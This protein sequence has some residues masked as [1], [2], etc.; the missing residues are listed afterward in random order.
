MIKISFYVVIFILVIL[1]IANLIKYHKKV[2]LVLECLS[3]FIMILDLLF[4]I[5]TFKQQENIENVFN[6]KVKIFK[7]E[8]KDIDVGNV[9]YSNDT[10]N[11][12]VE[13][14][15]L[16]SM[17]E[18][19]LLKISQNYYLG[20]DFEMI[21]EIYSMDKLKNNAVA[22]NNIGYMYANG[23]YYKQNLEMAKFYYDKS[24]ELGND[25]ALTNELAM[26]FNNKLKDIPDVLMKCFEKKNL[27]AGKFIYSRFED[28][29]LNDEN[30]C[31]DALANL[32]FLW[33]AEVEAGEIQNELPYTVDNSFYEWVN[34]GY[35]NLIYTP[36]NDKLTKYI[37][38]GDV[39]KLNLEAGYALIVGVYKCYKS[40][41][42][43]IDMLDESFQMIE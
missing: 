36:S 30:A 28:A 7:Q 40:K 38:V 9:V 19:E 42:I 12:I 18:E 41:C 15:D 2:S 10:I 13:K 11:N 33:Q 17:T 31:I 29:D 27:T 1:Y 6:E 23:I 22:L 5:Y 8:I 25:K 4:T 43:N 14:L 26:C 32:A 16:K 35:K 37:P 39:E 34:E 21:I 24:I 3:G 20:E